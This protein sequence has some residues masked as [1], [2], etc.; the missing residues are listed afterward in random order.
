MINNLND[1]FIKIINTLFPIT[2]YGC[3]KYIDNFG[4][5][6]DCWKKINWIG[7]PVCA[8][9]GKPFEFQKNSKCM[10]CARKK[11]SFDKAVS[12][13]EYNEQS[14]NIVL[15]FKNADSTFLGKE[16]ALMM[17]R[18]GRSLIENSDI[19]V[20]VPISFPRRFKRRYNQ[21]E[22]LARYIGKSGKKDYEPRVLAKNKNIRP[23]EGLNHKQRQ[24]NVK[25]AFYVNEKFRSSIDHKKVLL[26]DDVLTTG[27]T[28]N[29]CAKVLKNAGAKKVFVLTLARALK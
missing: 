2:C 29:E 12:V 21:T 10:D 25:N 9:C 5:C 22:I 6:S 1:F 18:A 26:I 20:P 17:S 28:V 15:R 13:F 4:L 3:G 16:L 24:E 27:A 19:V 23:Q 7:E 14:K 11:P 8:I